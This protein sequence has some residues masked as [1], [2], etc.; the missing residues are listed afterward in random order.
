[1][2]ERDN[3][4]PPSPQ[5]LHELLSATASPTQYDEGVPEISW[6][7]RQANA[8]PN[9]A[10][11]H[12]QRRSATNDVDTHTARKK[13]EDASADETS[14]GILSACP[15][16]SRAR[17]EQ[18]VDDVV[19]TQ[20][21]NEGQLLLEVGNALRKG[22][23]VLPESRQARPRVARGRER[24]DGDL[25]VVQRHEHRLENA[26]IPEQLPHFDAEQGHWVRG[27]EPI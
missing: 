2:Q 27:G 17:G 18:H 15:R 21:G 10:R 3:E 23:D 11:R 6:F 25:H 9:V 26:S 16:N 14:P 8:S 19:D 22:D 5:V 13:L 4:V 20:A 1:L 12:D 24:A 7:P